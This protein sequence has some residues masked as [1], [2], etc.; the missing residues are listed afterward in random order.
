[1]EIVFGARTRCGSQFLI[2]ISSALLGELPQPFSVITPGRVESMINENK[3]IFR[4]LYLQGYGWKYFDDY[5]IQTLKLEDPSIDFLGFSLLAKFPEAKWLTTY[6]NIEDVITS[7]Y[8][9]KSWGK[10]EEHVL[11][12]FLTSIDLMEQ[13]AHQKRLFI[14]NI[15][16]PE[17]FNINNMV[18]FL[19]CEVTKKA[20]YIASNWPKVNPLSYQKEKFSEKIKQKEKPPA[21]NTLRDRHPWIEE[22]EERY[23]QLWKRCS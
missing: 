15:D 5:S 11:R 8:N 10:S 1:M 17:N 6:R 12:S 2:K 3:K 7:H 23:F 16:A 20:N 21:L 13:I 4:K 22:I 14:I 9:I 18:K 19:E